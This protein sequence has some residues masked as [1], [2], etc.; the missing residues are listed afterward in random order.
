MCKLIFEKM[1]GSQKNG[2]L[3]WFGVPFWCSAAVLTVWWLFLSPIQ[4]R[5]LAHSLLWREL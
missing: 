3:Y 5:L 2:T 4:V 1:G